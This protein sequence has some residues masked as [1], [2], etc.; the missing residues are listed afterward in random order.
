MI[1]ASL[2]L[3]VCFIGFM[4][5]AF[6][7]G[8]RKSLQGLDDK[9]AA[10]SKTVETALQTLKEAE[11]K[12]NY[13]EKYDSLIQHEVQEIFKRVQ[14][15]VEELQQEMSADLDKMMQNRLASVDLQIDRL[16]KETMDELNLR[17]TNEAVKALGT[18]FQRYLPEKTHMAINDN[19]LDQLEQLLHN[20]GALKDDEMTQKKIAN[21]T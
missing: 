21:S 19:F 3:L 5:L 9:I 17:L 11:E 6:K 14:H 15:Q 1:D 10:V 20:E 13:E 2:I 8:Y 4:G 7:F 18:L 12:Y 16:R